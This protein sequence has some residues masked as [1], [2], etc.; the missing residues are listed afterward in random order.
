MSSNFTDDDIRY[1]QRAL[2]LAK[3]G[4]GKTYPN[5]AVGAVIVKD[6]D[7]ISEAYHEKAG[8]PHAE[9]K[10]ISASESDLRGATM[11]VTLEPCSHVGRTPPCTQ[12]IIDS[13][14]KDVFFACKD[15]T[16]H[17]GVSGEEV[18]RKCKINV[19]CGPLMNEAEELNRKYFKFV[20]TSLP[21]VTLK[22]A[23]TLDGKISAKDGSSKWITS[24]KA[25]EHA[26]RQRLSYSALIVGIN[27]VI[28]DDP[29]LLDEDRAS[30]PYTR[31]ILDSSLRLP[32]SSN[33]VRTAGSS[34]VLVAT[35]SKAEIAR[36]E[37]LEELGVEVKTYPEDS[38]KRVCIESL[39]QDMAKRDL[40]SVLVEGGGTVSG[41]FL[42]KACADEVVLYLAPKIIGA[43]RSSFAMTSTLKI[44]DAV[45]L[46]EI[47]LRELADDIF[48][49]AKIR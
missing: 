9:A 31:V 4:L 1:M 2:L 5:P 32:F 3:K 8:E 23:Q 42:D 14:I 38:R 28:A 22:S 11:Y 17:G 45:E 33:I 41:A 30:V 25:R 40:V 15:P 18:L 20:R 26:Y 29:F 44:S 27:T 34:P 12:K 47:K 46:K 39:L 35:T 16:E 6:N 24:L 37:K 21:Y 48:L 36:K 19:R 7:I 13:G 49:R 10:A 43:G